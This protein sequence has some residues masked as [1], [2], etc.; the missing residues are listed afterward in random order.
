M[1]R[2]TATSSV[3]NARKLREMGDYTLDPLN[4][5]IVGGLGSITILK[6]VQANGENVYISYVKDLECWSLSSKVM[7]KFIPHISQE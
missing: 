6:T 1:I 5:F 2:G 7:I 4:H 3:G